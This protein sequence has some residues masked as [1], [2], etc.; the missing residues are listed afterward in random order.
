MKVGRYHPAPVAI[1]AAIKV[2]TIEGLKCRLDSSFAQ[3]MRMQLSVQG[4]AA[5]IF[6]LLSLRACM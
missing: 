3:K 4:T 5:A 2:G 1:K 6:E